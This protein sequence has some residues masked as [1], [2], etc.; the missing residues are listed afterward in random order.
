MES[1]EGAG[2]TFRFTLPVV[3]SPA[4]SADHNAQQQPGEKSDSVSDSA[5]V[6]LK[7]STVA[8]G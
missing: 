3:E 7:C 2:A 5:A 1:K 8:Y 6:N 4:A